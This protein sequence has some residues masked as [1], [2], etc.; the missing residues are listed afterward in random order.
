[1]AQ[2]GYE[3]ASHGYGN[4]LV[5]TQTPTQFRKVVRRSKQILEDLIGKQVMGYRTPSF[6]VLSQTGW[7]IPVLLEEGYRYG[8]S[9]SCISIRRNLIPNSPHGLASAV[10]GSSL[11]ETR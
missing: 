6:S 11:P 9:M 10:K 5:Y 1:M 3:I 7:A 8:S 4:E 2:Q